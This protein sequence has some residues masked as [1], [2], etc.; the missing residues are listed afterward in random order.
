MAFIEIFLRTLQDYPIL[1]VFG[2]IGLFGLI[3]GSAWFKGLLGEFKVRVITDFYLPGKDYYP[4]HNVV[5]KTPDGTTQIDHILVSPFGV[6]VIETKNYKGWIFGDSRSRN[7]TQ[8]LFGK[9]YSFQNPLRQ[10]YKHVKAV[11]SVLGVDPK[12]IHSVVVFT[13]NSKFKT[14][15]PQNVTDLGS[16]LPYIKSKKEVVL[17]EG[18]RRQISRKLNFAGSGLLKFGI[19]KRHVQRLKK[20]AK[21]PICPKCGTKMSLR[22]ASKG[23]NAGNQFWGCVNFPKCRFTKPVQ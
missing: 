14:L 20:N 19:G 5:L 8:S 10:N 12:V 7:W 17:S 3:L 11:E 13:G 4:L 2:G 9:K 1:W 18:E 23:S 6:F 15:L 16:F 22:T 21:E